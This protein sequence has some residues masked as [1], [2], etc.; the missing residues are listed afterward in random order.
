MHDQL[1]WVN[2]LLFPSAIKNKRMEPPMTDRLAALIKRVAEL[3]QA[4][5]EACHRIEEFHLRRICPLGRR[6]TLAF[7]CP[8]MADPSRDPSKGDLFVLSSHC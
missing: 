1:P 2:N 7:E 3:R 8:W 5:L 4:S 6:K